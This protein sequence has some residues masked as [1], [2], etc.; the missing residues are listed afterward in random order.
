MGI[1]LYSNVY[2]LKQGIIYLYNNHNFNKVIEIHLEEELKKGK[3]S[4]DLPSLFMETERA[5][6]LREE[7]EAV[8]KN[9]AAQ[10]T[11][12]R[13]PKVYSDYVGTYKSEGM[14][15][16]L[17][18]DGDRLFMERDELPKLEMFPQ[19]ETT[20]VHPSLN[21]NLQTVFIRD[22]QGQVTRLIF[23]GFGMEFELKKD[24]ATSYPYWWVWLISAILIML[25]ALAGWYGWRKR[26][27]TL[28]Q[29]HVR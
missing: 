1:T 20:F 17:S 6:R 26:H 4:Y 23:R 3:Q 2:D 13:D 19:S 28:K 18:L 8:E 12:G 5:Q 7:A 16:R 21:G 15:I 22:E 25:L 29:I 11:A 24:K 10:A 14:T 27:H 9:L